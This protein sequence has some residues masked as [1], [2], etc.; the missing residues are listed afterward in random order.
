MEYYVALDGEKVGPLTQFRIVEMLREGVISAESKGWQKGMESWKPLSELPSLNSTFEVIQR[1]QESLPITDPISETLPESDVARSAISDS[2]SATQPISYEPVRTVKVAAEVRPLTRFWARYFDYTMVAV[3]VL[4]F[5]DVELPRVG[6][7]VAPAD[8]VTR[9]D[10]IFRRED[11]LALSK[12]MAYALLMWHVVEGFLVSLFGTTPGKAL[13]GIKVVTFS[14]QKMGIMQGIARSFLVFA[15]GLAFFSFY[16]L[17][18]A[19][20][21]FAFFRLMSRGNTVWDQAL[22]LEVNHPPLTFLRILLAFTAFF[23]LM[24]LQF[25]KI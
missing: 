11:L 2:K 23:A 9:R 22:K 8:L 24:M 25:V 7:D 12:M 3:L 19:A 1:E 4:L 6:P 20:M 21:A 5:S 14:G 15:L 18:L 16:F 13:F 10:E 17:T